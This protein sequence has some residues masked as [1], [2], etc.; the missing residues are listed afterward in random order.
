VL[1]G[2]RYYPVAIAK[3]KMV[4]KGFI[5]TNTDENEL[6]GWNGYQVTTNPD[7]AEVAQKFIQAN[8]LKD[9]DP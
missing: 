8:R 4:I 5:D 7:I 3:P 1:Y 9:R 2:D 6:T